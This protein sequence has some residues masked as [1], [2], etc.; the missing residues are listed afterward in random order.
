VSAVNYFLSNHLLYHRAL[1]EYW[2]WLV[3]SVLMAGGT[4]ILLMNFAGSRLRLEPGL[5]RKIRALLSHTFG[6]SSLL[7]LILASLS[8]SVSPAHAVQAEQGQEEDVNIAIDSQFKLVKMGQVVKFNTIITN[9]GLKTSAS[10]IAAINIINLEKTGESV[11]LAEWAPEQTQYIDALKPDES[12]KLDWIVTTGLQGDY[13]VYVV[14][15]PQ[16]KSAEV[17]THPI[18]S[19]SLYLTVESSPRLQPGTV[20]PFALGVP[21][22]LLAITFVVYRRRSQQ[23]DVSDPL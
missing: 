10:L 17:T 19:S 2:P 11:D 8:F 20:L 5:R 14:L 4:V 6:L 15:I 21:V 7:M 1:G 9:N 22:L 23:I 18:A 3:S 16:P 13:M 12:L